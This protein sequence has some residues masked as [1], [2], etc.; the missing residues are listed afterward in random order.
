MGVRPKMHLHRT[1]V[2]CKMH[3]Q[4]CTC[5]APPPGAGRIYLGTCTARAK[6][7]ASQPIPTYSNLFQPI[8]RSQPIPTY[9]P[10]PTYPNLSSSIPTYPPP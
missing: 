2:G 1:G 3:L 4:R 8:L 6:A 9:P 7:G 5:T 10:L